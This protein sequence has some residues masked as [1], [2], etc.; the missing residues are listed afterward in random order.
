MTQLLQQLING[1]ILGAVYALFAEG[2]A[3][4]FGTMGVLDLAHGA[5]LMI[6]AFVG[7]FLVTDYHIPVLVAFLLSMFVAGVASVAVEQATL[8]PLRNRGG[9][10]GG[11]A[12]IVTTLGAAGVLETW[13]QVTS[14][15]QVL[16]YPQVSWLQHVIVIG[17]LYL[18]TLQFVVVGVTLVLGASLI[19][20]LQKTQTGIRVRAL[21]ADHDGAD[22][23]GVN[24][25]AL[26]AAIFFVGGALAGAT[27]VLV[28]LLFASVQFQMGQPYLL[29]GVVVVTIGG[30]GSISGAIVAGL[31]VGII[32][33]LVTGYF[34]SN[35]SEIIVFLL[36]IIF[37]I[38]RPSGLFGAYVRTRRATRA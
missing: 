2:F 28:S 27:G 18:S 35:L 32:T 30:L 34:S 36:M 14:H 29:I 15:T 33:S 23:L 3:V 22:L 16:T 9:E 5:V 17:P 7:Y 6:G 25:T 12:V 8:R 31:S 10:A 11:F 37:L 26:Y 38:V 24:T 4:I 1:L 13:G 20:L 21:A 19:F